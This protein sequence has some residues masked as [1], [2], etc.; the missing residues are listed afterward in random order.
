M[1]RSSPGRSKLP[2]WRMKYSVPSGLFVEGIRT[3]YCGTMRGAHEVVPFNYDVRDHHYVHSVAS[4]V[5][6]A[7]CSGG[8]FPFDS[9]TGHTCGRK[10]VFFNDYCTKAW[11]G[12]ESKF[13]QAHSKLIS[14]S[15]NG[16]VRRKIQNTWAGRVQWILNTAASQTIPRSLEKRRKFHPWTAPSDIEA[17]SGMRTRTAKDGKEE[18][19]NTRVEILNRECKA[20]VELN[21]RS[22]EQEYQKLVV[23]SI[24]H[25]R[26]RMSNNDHGR[27]RNGAGKEH[28]Q[29]N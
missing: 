21:F 15:L 10:Q 5:V 23:V 11:I 17:Q 29:L 28:G 13:I 20:G 7:I 22:R 1:H 2:W 9:G 27:G 12:V 6:I 18:L 26:R 8:E 25:R 16:P 14:I 24:W 19:R 4:V 3:F